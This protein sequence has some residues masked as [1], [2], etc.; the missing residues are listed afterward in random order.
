VSTHAFCHNDETVR[1][2]YARRTNRRCVCI[3]RHAITIQYSVRSHFMLAKHDGS[4]SNANSIG[5][6]VFMQDVF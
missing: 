1:A 2:V 6:N 4:V 5:W 3:L